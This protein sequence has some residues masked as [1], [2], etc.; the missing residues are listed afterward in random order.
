VLLGGI[1]AR[2]ISVS[3]I[4]AVMLTAGFYIIPI[5]RFIACITTF[6][7]GIP[8]PLPVSGEFGFVFLLPTFTASLHNRTPDVYCH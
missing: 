3:V 1:I 2:Y 8:H 7:T 6:L 4:N 5:A